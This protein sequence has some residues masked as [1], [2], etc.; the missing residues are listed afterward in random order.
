MECEKVNCYQ[1]ILDAIAK[2]RKLFTILID[3]EKC[4]SKKLEQY[5][6][7]INAN[8]VD[9][10]FVGGSQMQCSVT[11]TV[12]FLRSRLSIPIV[13]FP[14][15]A[16]QFA[17]N[18]DAILL[19]SLISGRNA[20]FLIGQQV[21]ASKMLKKS[22][23]EI[24]PTGY[25]LID[26][27]RESATE[28]VSKTQPISATDTELIVA[29]ALAGEQLGLRLIYLEAGS[30]ALAPVSKEVIAAVHAELSVPLIVGGGIKTREDLLAAYASG[31][32]MVVVGNALEENP[33]K[34]SEILSV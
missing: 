16:L 31:A 30:G 25:V 20:E 26:G 24:L 32:D 1:Y 4:D 11:E 10:V 21:K 22:A 3:P 33:N 8:P 2:G 6:N 5:A 13:L 15:N 17:E 9:F 12:S 18:S 7:A 14:G 34:L 19:L 27:G 23:I 28:K 29:T